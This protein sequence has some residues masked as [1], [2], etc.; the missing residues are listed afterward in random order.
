MGVSGLSG[1]MDVCHCSC[2]PGLRSAA[3]NTART[4]GSAAAAAVSMPRIAA[5]A[6]GLRTK[7]AWS[8][9]GSTTS[10]T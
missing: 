1:P 8:S 6:Y 3:V 2:M 4:P 9:P 5:C 7:A 10:S